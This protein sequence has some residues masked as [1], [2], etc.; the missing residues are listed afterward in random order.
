MFRCALK[1]GGG[2]ICSLL[3]H[4]KFARARAAASDVMQEVGALGCGEWRAALYVL[5]MCYC[6]YVFMFLQIDACIH[7]PLHVNVR[8]DVKMH[9]YCGDTLVRTSIMIRYSS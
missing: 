9:W 4:V 2:C 3:L 6:P 8:G 1:F 5:V 7:L